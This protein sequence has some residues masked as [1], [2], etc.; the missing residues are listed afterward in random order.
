MLK[1]S[2][3][4]TKLFLSSNVFLRQ[5]RDICLRS[6][7]VG[8]FP[9]CWRRDQIHFIYKNK[10]ERSDASNWRPITIA[11]SLGKHLERLFTILISP[12]DDLNYSNHAYKSQRSCLTAIA[13]AQQKLL[14]AKLTS[15]KANRRGK[16]LSVL[17]FDDIAGA[18]ESIDH[19]LVSYA[20][21]KMMAKE[22]LAR[23]SNFLKSYLDRIAQVVDEVTGAT[24]DVV[25]K[26]LT[27]TAPQGSLLSS[28]LWRIY[29]HIFS[30]LYRENL[31]LL[32]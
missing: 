5:Y 11:P 3:K 20:I 17:S 7:T 22:K 21:D 9:A 14:W 6:L 18:F 8:Y 24:C 10:G 27:K 4:E 31:Q 19:I 25:R 13:A 12:A 2:L 1:L 28:A 29:D 16:L 23:V 15:K 26:I 30:E 32:E